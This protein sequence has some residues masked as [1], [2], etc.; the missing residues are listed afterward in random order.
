MLV[1]MTTPK[2][3]A[4][5][6]T[7]AHRGAGRPRDAA[8]DEAILGAARAL[9][10]ESG[11]AAVTMSAVVRRSGVA[12]A[13][14]YRRW[15]NREALVVATLRRSMGPP[16][17]VPTGDLETDI[18]GGARLA[19]QIL[20][21]E[22]L[23]PLLP[24]LFA[25]TLAPPDEGG[26]IAFDEFAPGRPRFVAAYQAELGPDATLAVDVLF[27]TLIGKLLM[28]GT[29]AT[30]EDADALADFILA[31]LERKARVAARQATG[32]GGKRS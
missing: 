1:W 18:R 29:P 9:L 4:L 13:T 8:A 15:P 7:G 32:S 27:G 26:H 12:R 25:A 20:A 23:R 16:A 3:P 10:A 28:N 21:S 22:A 14:V 24:A 19:Q 17:L 5:D 31:G 6:P 30:P 2:A 11:V